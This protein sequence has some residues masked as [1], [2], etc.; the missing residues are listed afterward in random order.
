MFLPNEPRVNC[1]PKVAG[2]KEA[3]S[4]LQGASTEGEALSDSEP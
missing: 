4:Q 2:G 3:S 1:H